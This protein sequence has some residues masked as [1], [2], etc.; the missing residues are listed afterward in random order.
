MSAGTGSNNNSTDAPTSSNYTSGVFFGVFI[1]SL[2]G[3]FL[4][5]CFRRCQRRRIV[6]AAVNRGALSSPYQ[7][8][9]IYTANVRVE[10]EESDLTVNSGPVVPLRWPPLSATSSAN[11][12]PVVKDS[13]FYPPPPLQISIESTDVPSVS[14][15]A[16]IVPNKTFNK[17]G[18]TIITSKDNDS[19]YLGDYIHTPS[20]SR[21]EALKGELPVED[22]PTFDPPSYCSRRKDVET[23]EEEEKAE[24][25]E[26]QIVPLD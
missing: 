17:E 12:F 10:E 21:K 22:G 16:Y 23:A 19:T 1:L 8:H 20:K 11:S 6:N 4:Y 18:L 9:D 5:I 7:F 13:L 26:M 3:I 25:I 14:P 15:P 24:E 2:I